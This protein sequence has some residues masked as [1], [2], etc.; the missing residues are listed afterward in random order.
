[1]G[2]R[3]LFILAILPASFLHVLPQ[4]PRAGFA[5]VEV[6]RGIYDDTF[7]RGGRFLLGAEGRDEGGD[8]A[9][10][11]VADTDPRPHARV[12]FRVRLMI[13]HVKDIVAVDVDSARTAELLPL[14]EEIAILVEDLNAIVAA[15]ADEDPSLRIDGDGVRRVE[16]AG[17]RAFLAPRLDELPILR[18]LHDARVGV[19][20]MSI[21]HENIAVRR[22]H[23]VARTIEGVGAVTSTPRLA[24]RHQHL[25][26]LAE[27]EYLVTLAI[28][29]GRVG[30]PD[31]AVAVDMETVRLIEHSLAKHL[32]DLARRIELNDRRDVR[33]LTGVLP[34]H[35][36]NAQILPSRSISTPMVAPHFLPS[37]S[38]A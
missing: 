31:V 11:G 23:Y 5:R 16:L 25:S 30:R 35:L 6:A 19:P 32:Q 13:G 14:R 3:H 15:V 33:A 8:V 4:I 9:I 28:F 20:A 22:G 29:A 36:S 1:R 7:G 34:P 24:E 26:F 27:F 37:G 38:L 18:E 12:V 17:G 21:C 2:R 10:L